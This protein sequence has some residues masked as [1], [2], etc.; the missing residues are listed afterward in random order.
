[1]RHEIASNW[2]I[3]QSKEIYKTYGGTFNFNWA[4]ATCNNQTI[5]SLNPKSR[6][7]R[8]Q[9]LKKWNPVLHLSSTTTNGFLNCS[10]HSNVK[11][12]NSIRISSSINQEKFY[13]TCGDHYSS[14]WTKTTR[15]NQNFDSLNP[16]SGVRRAQGPI[17]GD[18]NLQLSS[19][20]NGYLSNSC[21]AVWSME[22]HQNQLIQN[23]REI[24]ESCSGNSKPNSTQHNTPHT[25]ATNSDA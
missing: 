5:K 23:W 7:Y 10:S 13:G 1:M 14:N 8:A 18:P 2:L 4:I 17:N 11:A 12:W 16:K 22:L 25:A 15:S 19:T 24:Y 6:V 20:A 21:T 3:Q 9:G